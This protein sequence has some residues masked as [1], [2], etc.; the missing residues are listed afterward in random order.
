MSV[1][2]GGGDESQRDLTYLR[3]VFLFQGLDDKQISRIMGLSRRA[4]VA[5]GETLV[6]E[7]EQG[8]T[9]YVILKGEVEVSKNLTLPMESAGSTQQEKALTRHS[10]RDRAIFGELVLFEDQTRSATVRCLTDCVFLELDK[11]AFLELA[12]DNPEI[13]Y[14]LFKN[15]SQMLSARLRRANNDIIKLT[16]ALSIALSG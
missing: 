1:Q 2:A 8:E 11:G 5:S 10:D 6:R 7:G 9:L 4:E 12:A 16:T 13:G 14:H 3:G 15:L